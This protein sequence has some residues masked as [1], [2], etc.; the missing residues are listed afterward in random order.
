MP[1]LTRHL[2]CCAGGAGA[3][4]PAR[5]RRFGRRTRH[6]AAAGCFHAGRALLP[7]H[8]SVCRSLSTRTCGPTLEAWEEPCRALECTIS[9]HT[10]GALGCLLLHGT[11]TA[12][13]LQLFLR[14]CCQGLQ[15]QVLHQLP[16]RATIPAPTGLDS[17]LGAA[18]AAGGS[19]RSQ[20]ACTPATGEARRCALLCCAVLCCAL[21]C[22]AMLF[23][24]GLDGTEQRGGH[25]TW[26]QIFP[27]CVGL[28]ADGPS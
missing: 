1:A 16:C 22:R 23:S 15:C 4:V 24:C 20:K 17:R 14:S 8:R 3:S 27:G 7:G 11:A 21:V 9:S 18:A 13:Q 10:W 28:H 5:T 2:L 25:P 6:C 26:Y 12:L 19:A